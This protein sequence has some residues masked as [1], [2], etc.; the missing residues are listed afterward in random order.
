METNNKKDTVPA[1]MDYL[2]TNREII[3]AY[4]EKLI[5]SGEYIMDEDLM[6]DMGSYPVGYTI[7]EQ[8]SVEDLQSIIGNSIHQLHHDERQVKDAD[9]KPVKQD[10]IDK[11]LAWHRNVLFN[12]LDHLAKDNGFNVTKEQLE[13]ELTPEIDAILALN[14]KADSL[15]VLN[16]LL[17]EYTTDTK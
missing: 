11:F 7:P 15:T 3:Q 16:A 17:D 6:G 13:N 4:N 14:P 12:T 5:Q 8:S 9:G 10:L 2:K 1:F